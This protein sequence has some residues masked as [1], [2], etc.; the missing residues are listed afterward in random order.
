MGQVTE[1]ALRIFITEMTRAQ[2]VE[3]I[4]REGQVEALICNIAHSAL[5]DDLKDLA[6][7]IYLVLLEYDEDKIIDLWEHKQMRYFICR[8]II[9]QTR[10][11]HS[12]WHDTFRKPRLRSVSISPGSGFDIAD[13]D[14][15]V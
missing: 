8:I 10:T 2:I 5:T 11:S 4:A 3:Q 12:P 14:T 15:T 13:K 7:M 6:Q 1:W 9:N